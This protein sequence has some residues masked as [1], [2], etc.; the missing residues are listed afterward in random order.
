MNKSSHKKNQVTLGDI[1]KQL[2]VSKVTVSKA[3]RDH[4][5]ISAAT[6]RRVKETAQALGYYPNYMARNL[7]SRRT[8]TV[9]VIVPKI[10]HYFFASVIEGIYDAAFANHYEIIMTVSQENGERE[11]HHVRSLLSMRVDGL[12]ISLSENSLD[13]SIYHSAQDMG[14]PIT[15]MDRVPESGGFN[16]VVADDYGGAYTATEHVIYAGFTKI[17]HIGGFGNINIGKE[18]YRGFETAMKEHDVAIR[19]EWVVRGGFGEEDGYRGFMKLYESRPLPEII[20]TVTFPVAF[21]MYKAANQLGLKI[22][23]DIDIICFGSSGVNQFL[24]TPMSYIEQPTYELGQR[25]FE[26][27]VENIHGTEQT[28]PKKITLPTKLVL[29]KTALPRNSGRVKQTAVTEG[30]PVTLK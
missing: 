3:L 14:V 18:R 8:N 5:D 7:S 12:I 6:I 15:F 27:T 26:L 1:A 30:K 16:S 25:A 17:G 21:G 13:Y 9:G 2:S 20:F 19:N 28:I 10:A 23:D 11:L 29:N 4:P 22:P 24:A